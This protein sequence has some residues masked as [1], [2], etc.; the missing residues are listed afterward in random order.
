MLH[1][2]LELHREQLAES[3]DRR[4]ERLGVLRYRR[5]V[6]LR[7]RGKVLVIAA[8]RYAVLTLREFARLAGFNV[9]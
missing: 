6:A 3:E 9:L 7:N 8:G 2:A 4:A 5:Q 1:R